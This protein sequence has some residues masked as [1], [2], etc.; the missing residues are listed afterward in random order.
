MMLCNSAK[1]HGFLW[2]RVINMFKLK[3]RT[4]NQAFEVPEGNQATEVIRILQDAIDKLEEG[5]RNGILLDCNGNLV[6]K[7]TLTNR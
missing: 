5:T 3:I 1:H 2:C 6:G 4:D 7:F